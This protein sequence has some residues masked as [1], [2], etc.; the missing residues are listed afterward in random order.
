M[1]L[2]SGGETLE[3]SNRVCS[4]SAGTDTNPIFMFSSDLE[5]RNPPAPW[6]SIENGEASFRPMCQY[7]DSPVSLSTQ[8]SD[9]DLKAEVDRCLELRAEYKTVVQRAQLAQTFYDLGKEELKFCDKLVHEQHLQH[10]GW[11]A[12]I[13]NMEDIT[14]EF[15]ERCSDF[16]RVFKDHI[17]KRIEYKD[18]LERLVADDNV[19][20]PVR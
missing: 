18:Y 14:F 11:M 4:Y 8:I 9:T 17:E 7:H 15:S 12:V 3:L 1:L 13:A 5:Q 16:D 6:P 2:V 19:A 20:E 10:Q